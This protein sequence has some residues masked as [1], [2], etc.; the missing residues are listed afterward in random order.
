M[1]LM[2]ILL[3]MVC[4]GYPARQLR[5]RRVFDYRRVGNVKKEREDVM[6]AKVGRWIGRVGLVVL[7]MGATP[8]FAWWGARHIKSAADIEAIMALRTGYTEAKDELDA[9][10]LTATTA[11]KYAFYG[12]LFNS[13]TILGLNGTATSA[14]REYYFIR[15]AHLGHP[16]AQN[17]CDRKGWSY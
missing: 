8:A 15:A 13:T 9:F 12:C 5:K 1:L 4:R 11:E 3:C 2:N 14:N 17:V 16:F 10:L 6:S 7:L